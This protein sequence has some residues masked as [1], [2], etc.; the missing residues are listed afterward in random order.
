MAADPGGA[1]P[2]RYK[3]FGLTVA[4]DIHLPELFPAADHEATDVRIAW[5]A[6]AAPPAEA[7]SAWGLTGDGHEAVLSVEGTG[8]YAIRGGSSIVVDP[9]NGAS[10]KSV[11]LF[12]LGSAFGAL[13]HQ[14]RLLPLHAN[15][16][17]IGGRAVAF[18]GRSG[19]GKS[20]MASRFMER[21]YRLLADDVCVVKFDSA[22]Q[23]MAQPG[24]PRLRLWRDAVEA[25]GWQPGDLEL[26]FEGQDKFVVPIHH[27]QTRQ[28]VPLKRIYLLA[29]LAP[30]ERG[31]R[32]R[33][34]TGSAAVQGIIANTYRG[35]YLS[36]LGGTERLLWDALRLVQT[37]AVF[38]VERQW[39]YDALQAQ[40]AGIEAHATGAEAQD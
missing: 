3:L 7:S 9:H 10:P 27:M 21:G 12:L 11:L 26:A 23:P 1:A 19:A 31:Q 34:L 16:I 14:R 37:V 15:A 24:P 5:G 25:S 17:E 30:G 4:S 8:R 6:V 38:E 40:I 33:R 22:G 13:L 29:A 28:A 32:I 35:Q 2:H 36:L 18:A 39:G 20:T